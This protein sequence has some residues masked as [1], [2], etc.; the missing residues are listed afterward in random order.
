E[1]APLTVPR[2]SHDAVVIGDKIYVVGGWQLEGDSDGTWQDEVLA[3]DLTRPGSTWEVVTKTPFR[4]RAL[5]AAHLGGKLVVLGGMTEDREITCAVDV[6]DPA[7]GEWSKLPEFPGEEDSMDGFGISAWNCDGKVYAS[8]F[9]GTI[10]G[11]AAS[12]WEKVAELDT[13]RSFHR[14]LPGPQLP[15]T[16]QSLLVVAG[17]SAEGHLGDIELV[18]LEN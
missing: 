18:E 7:T 12:G 17:A 11:L 10:H 1:L 9:G 8:S 13:P 5:A 16:K 4:R 15:E 2:S 14:I 6:F 3:F